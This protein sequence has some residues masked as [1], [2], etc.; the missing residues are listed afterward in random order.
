MKKIDR[1]AYYDELLD[2]IET[3]GCPFCRLLYKS[4]NRYVDS[5]LYDRATDPPE[6]AKINAARGFCP[7]HAALMVR[8]G[9]AL[10]AAFIE[11][12][13]FKL[14]L[15]EMA[16]NPLDGKG[17]WRG[18][19]SNR[20]PEA[21]TPLG[22]LLSAL[23]PQAPCPVCADLAEVEAN[24]ISTLLQNLE[25]QER[26]TAAYR[27]SSGLCLVHF[28][29]TLAQA[30]PGEHTERLVAVQIEI[31]RRLHGELSEFIRKN[32]YRYRG[33]A[34]GEEKDSW[35]R[36]IEA[37]AGTLPQSRDNLKGITQS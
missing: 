29:N 12:G 20:E 6:R 26:M 11:Q 17:S 19:L 33:E 10:G 28:R 7:E 14:L 24:L 36:A 37:N 21:N 4:A 3:A 22:R 1:K 9:A 25:E 15:D 18:R 27:A 31:W 35:L 13:V 8:P 2:A 5:V 34:F 32:D 16:Q 23:R 30:R